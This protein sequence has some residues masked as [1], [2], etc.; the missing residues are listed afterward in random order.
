MAFPINP[1][2]KLVKNI[3]GDIAFVKKQTGDSEPYQIT[4]IPLN[5]ENGEYQQYLEWVSEGNT[6]EEA[7]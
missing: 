3:D 4:I 6:A 1:I 5:K 7:D 2:Y